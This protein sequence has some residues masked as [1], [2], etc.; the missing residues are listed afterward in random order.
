MVKQQSKIVI[1]VRHV[2]TSPP[3]VPHTPTAPLVFLFHRQRAFWAPSL[4][5]WV[6]WASRP[7]HHLTR[8]WGLSRLP[9]PVSE[10]SLS[11]E[12]F[13]FGTQVPVAMGKEEMFWPHRPQP[14]RAG[15]CSAPAWASP[16]PSDPTLME[17]TLLLR[18]PYAKGRHHTPCDAS[19]PETTAQLR[20]M[21]CAAGRQE[22][23]L[24]AARI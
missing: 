1:E 15:I 18:Q 20:A 6:H 10:L 17:A 21:G 14:T 23:V 3:L 4:L 9:V 5:F 2:P 19:P 24:P 16:A 11:P 13:A 8:A 22:A 7:L 12:T